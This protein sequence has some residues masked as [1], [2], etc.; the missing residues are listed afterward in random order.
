ML[1]KKIKIKSKNGLHTRPAAQLVKEAKKYNSDITIISNGKEA[2]A[3]SLFK[4][5][6][7]GLTQGSNIILSINGID[8]QK[9]MNEISIFIKKLI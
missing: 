7:L 2:N 6:T 5:Q 4:L 1:Q 9:A 8:E 3:K